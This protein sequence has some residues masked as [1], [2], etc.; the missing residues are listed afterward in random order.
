MSRVL[1]VAGLML[2]VPAFAS[3]Q[4]VDPG[5]SKPLIPRAQYGEPKPLKAARAAECPN[6]QGPV[7]QAQAEYY[8][9]SGPYGRRLQAQLWWEY[10]ECAPD[11]CP[12]PIGCG[13]GFT[14]RKFIFGSCRQFFGNASAAEGHGRAG[15]QERP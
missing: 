11:G 2:L 6:C 10:H 13:N 3:A 12:K 4:S 15:S 7:Q 1:F 14:E 9:G 8:A 5:A